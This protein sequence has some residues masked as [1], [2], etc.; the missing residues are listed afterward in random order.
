LYYS[1][2]SQAARAIILSLVLDVVFIYGPTSP[3]HLF[4]INGSWLLA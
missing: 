1:S 3:A 2:V 4:G